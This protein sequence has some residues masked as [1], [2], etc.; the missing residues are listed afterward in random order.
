MSAVNHPPGYILAQSC[1]TILMEDL[2]GDRRTLCNCE[3]LA[4]G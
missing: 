1:E 2:L 3:Q 4:I